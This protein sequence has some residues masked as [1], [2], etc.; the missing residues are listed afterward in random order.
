M[1]R[2]MLRTFFALDAVLHL[3]SCK[4]LGFKVSRKTI[5]NWQKDFEQTGTVSERKAGSALGWCDQHG[6]RRSR[7][8]DGPLSTMFLEKR[9]AGPWSKKAKLLACEGRRQCSRQ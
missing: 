8:A 2:H 5:F 9:Y 3:C 7:H 1:S 4:K 6:G